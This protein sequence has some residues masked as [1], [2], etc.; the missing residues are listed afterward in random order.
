MQ[1]M[2][3]ASMV[4]DVTKRLERLAKKAAR[5]GVP[6][7]YTVGD[8]HPCVVNV[9]AF[10]YV[11]HEQYIERSYTVAAVDID[12]DCDG[13]IM[14][15]GWRVLARIEHGDKGNIV[16]AFGGAEIR[17]EWY[18]APSRC[19][20]CGTNR[21][22]SVTFIV[23]HENGDVRQVGKSCLKDYTGIAPALALM[24]AEVGD[25]FPG[26]DCTASEWGERHPA[27]MYSTVKVLAH[28]F[29][30]IRARGY[31]KSNDNN[32]TRE[33]VADKVREEIAPSDA[34]IAEAEKMVEWLVTCGAKD[35]ADDAELRTLY[36]TAFDEFGDGAKAD[37][38]A[39]YK[40]CAAVYRAWGRLGNLE[41]DCVPFA[42]S[43]YTKSSGIGRLCYIP[44]AYKKYL[45]RKA[46][47]EAKEADRQ[48]AREASNHVGNV[49]DRIE[50]V[51]V[52]VE[53]V[54]S[55]ETAYGR[56]FLY[57]FTDAN[58]NVFV[59]F[60]SG[61]FLERN[62]ITVRGTIKTHDERDGVKQTV[63]TR[64]RIIEGR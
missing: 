4:G 27:V 8:E 28:A 35:D 9:Y 22:R 41:R 5:Y 18:N 60:A 45:A 46:D 26:M 24:W 51:A 48:I 10:D 30:E 36:E 32:S 58:G 44:V 16:T 6:F 25:I 20:H 21:A 11:N 55:W 47:A 64:C 3:H 1:R 33:A 57:R 63:L 38:D 31:I 29:D 23:E 39:Y 37:Q 15:D 17:P 43:G 49:G 53:C 56:T 54:A 50:F 14:A 42:R 61:A 12:V 19:D 62:G 7:S 59:W 40:R 34:G 2:V 52:K 13:F